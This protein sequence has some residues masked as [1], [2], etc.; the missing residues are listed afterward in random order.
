MAITWKFRRGNEEENDVF[1]GE[2]GELTI[3][4]TNN[5]IRVHD[6]VSVGG[7]ELSNLTYRI[8]DIGKVS[9]VKL[10]FIAGENLSLGDLCYIGA[11]FKLYKANASSETTTPC[12]AVVLANV[13]VDE[14]VSCLI[15]GIITLDGITLSAGKI[16]LSTTGTFTQ[17]P[18]QNENNIGQVLG[19][20]LSSNS[21]L[22]RPSLD[23]IVVGV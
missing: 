9:G 5:T 16:Y 19:I 7:T 21:I 14:S 6:G 1:T 15:D 17:I 8:P 2:S 11:D 18:P 23:T 13:L 20:A 4:T 10:P 22:F 12:I 3:D